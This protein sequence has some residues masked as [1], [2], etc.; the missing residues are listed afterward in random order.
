MNDTMVVAVHCPFCQKS[1][2]VEVPVKGFLAWQS[3]ELIQNAMPEVDADSR[4]QLISGTCSK[5]WDKMFPCSED[6]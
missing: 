6:E 4:E 5:C 2:E 1:A 3:G